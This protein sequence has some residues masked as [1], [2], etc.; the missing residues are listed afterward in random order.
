M[1]YLFVLKANRIGRYLQRYFAVLSLSF[2]V[3][4]TSLSLT[5]KNRKTKSL[6]GLKE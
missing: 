5:L 6:E 1:G 2:T 3:D 4:F